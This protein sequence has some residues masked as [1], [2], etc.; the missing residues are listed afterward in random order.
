MDTV[1][2]HLEMALN[3]GLMHEDEIIDYMVGH[4]GAA[5]ELLN[6]SAPQCL[7]NPPHCSHRLVPDPPLT[8]E[9][10]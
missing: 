6:A 1:R 7:D 4:I 10:S 9:P 5:I 3:P 2:G 8:E